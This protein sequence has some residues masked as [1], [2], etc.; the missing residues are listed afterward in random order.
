MAKRCWS[1]W[2]KTILRSGVA[3]CVI[4]VAG[5]LGVVVSDDGPA[6]GDSQRMAGVDEAAGG[7]GGEA[8]R[9]SAEGG[10]ALQLIRTANACGL[11]ASSCFKCH[12]GQRAEAPK[13]AAWHQEHADVNYSCDGCHGGNP[14]LLKKTIAHSG[15]L[16]NPVEAPDK[17][18]VDCHQGDDVDALVAKYQEVLGG[19][20]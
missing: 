7:W 18:C 12:N 6:S 10:M 11:G 5:V 15:L 4:T 9:S 16:A 17:A 8:P 2:G 19:G 3:L 20:Q 13:E 1:G 14:R